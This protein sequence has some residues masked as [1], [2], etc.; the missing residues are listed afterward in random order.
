M[1]DKVTTNKVHVVDD[2]QQRNFNTTRLEKDGANHTK[3]T[4][5]EQCKEDGRD[6]LEDGLEEN[7]PDGVRK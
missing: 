4:H 6:A 2:L 3:Q 1:L 5:A 7:S